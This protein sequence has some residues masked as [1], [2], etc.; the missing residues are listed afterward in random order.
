M[1]LRFSFFVIRV[2]FALLPKG[3]LFPIG[4]YFL[5]LS[6]QKMDRATFTIVDRV[7]MYVGGELTLTM[8]V[9]C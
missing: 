3:Q 7:I 9:Q 8:R 5:F 2:E 1:I 4:Q 6:S